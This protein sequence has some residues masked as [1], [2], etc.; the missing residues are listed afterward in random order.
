[1]EE[2]SVVSTNTEND[3]ESPSTSSSLSNRN[4]CSIG[5][6]D[7]IAIDAVINDEEEVSDKLFSNTNCFKYGKHCKIKMGNADDAHPDIVAMSVLSLYDKETLETD[8]DT[9]KYDLF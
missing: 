5:H 1:M 7:N 4:T 6:A 2:P 3:N 8:M 9:E